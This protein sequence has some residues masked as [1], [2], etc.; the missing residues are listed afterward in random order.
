MK[1]IILSLILMP[2]LVFASS[3]SDLAREQSFKKFFE[4]FDKNPA[5]ASK[6][7]PAKFNNQ[8]ERITHPKKYFSDAEIRNKSFIKAKN[9]FRHQIAQA[10]RYFALVDGNND[11]RV[12]FS[13]DANILKNIS[14]F[15]LDNFNQ[16]TLSQQPWSGDYWGTY[17]G[18]IGVRY[19]DIHFPFSFNFKENFD[20]FKTSYWP[21]DY[22]N[23]E[24]IDLL[25]ASEKYDLLVGDS[26][27]TLTKA[28]W[29]EGQKYNEA[30]GKVPTWFGICDGWS[31]SSLTLP[32]PQKSFQVPVQTPNGNTVQIT[33]YPNDLKALASS[34]WAKGY[35][36]HSFV[37]GRCDQ[38]KPKRDRES[39]RLTDAECFDINP[40]ALHLLL[41]NRLHQS[42]KGF[43][44]DANF[45]SEV[46]N[47]PVIGYD[48][49]YFNPQT[50]E[51]SKNPRDVMISYSTYTND[52]FKKYRKSN[53]KSI[54]GV[55]IKISYM[56]ESNPRHIPTDSPENDNI[57]A[58]QY[59]YDLEIDE[60]NNLI[61][62][63][64]Y[65]NAHPDFIWAPKGDSRAVSFYESYTDG[66]W[67]G[68]S[69]I[70]KTWL[71]YIQKSSEKI[72]PFAKV[73]EKLFELSQ[74]K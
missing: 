48:L 63:E 4:L 44:M 31:G 67:D 60:Q 61:G 15:S 23:N 74:E 34:L 14:D 29:Q 36:E 57:T 1:K 26:N 53:V 56:T 18:G 2:V 46:W 24:A 45:D 5:A 22:N 12:F 58:V 59:M 38:E 3:S 71:P 69:P 49:V 30:Y 73:V 43:V 8:G 37:G 65:Q 68:N 72:Q 16:F 52:K 19:A 17:K 54:V 39:G 42:D 10:S 51:R 32:R 35:Y 41:I 6:I 50:K 20:Y 66:Q 55:D 70:S 11:I 13:S 47:Q 28:A 25:S 33:F 21:L 27:F 7:T 40:T 62:G 9:K 64:W